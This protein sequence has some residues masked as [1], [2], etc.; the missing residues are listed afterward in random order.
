[1]GAATTGS[2]EREVALSPE[3]LLP[4]RLGDA[5]SWGSEVGT[6]HTFSPGSLGA[7]PAP[8]REGARSSP[9]KR[10]L[11]GLVGMGRSEGLYPSLP[12]NW[13]RDPEK[14]SQPAAPN[15]EQERRGTR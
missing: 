11:R 10:R 9:R 3:D 2:V 14:P 8:S 6:Q 12:Y 15:L 4:L 13:H 7:Q 5:A 1:M